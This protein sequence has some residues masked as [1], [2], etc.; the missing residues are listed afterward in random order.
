[1][2]Q[3]LNAAVRKAQTSSALLIDDYGFLHF[4]KTGLTEEAI[5]V[6]ALDVL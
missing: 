6:D 3:R 1:V 2:Q 4:L 5:V